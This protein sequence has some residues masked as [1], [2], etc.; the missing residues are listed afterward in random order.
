MNTLVLH[1]IAQINILSNEFNV[2]KKISAVVW[3]STL[4]I[5]ASRKPEVRRKEPRRWI[6]YTLLD[7]IVQKV[8]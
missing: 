1:S 7:D 5:T 8:F 2:D 3:F 6:Y 4:Y